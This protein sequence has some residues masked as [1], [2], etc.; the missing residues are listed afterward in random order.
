MATSRL[1]IKIVLLMPLLISCSDQTE[2]KSTDI[3]LTD[4]NAT[5]E[6]Q[7]L[8]HNLNSIRHNHILFGHQDA[9]A[10]GVTWRD[11]EGRSDVKDVAGSYPALYGWDLG[12]LELGS[13]KNLDKV[14]F[15]DIHRWIIEAFERGGVITLSW[16]LNHPVTGNRI[17]KEHNPDDWEVEG[18]A[19]D[20]TP[21][22]NDILP[23]GSHEEVFKEWLDTIA[24][25]MKSLKSSDGRSIPVIFRPYHEVTGH[26]F[27]WATEA[28]TPDEYIALWRYTVEYLRDHR[29]VNNLLYA[30]TPNSL[31]EIEW[32]EFW[33]WYPG[34]DYVDIIGFD[35]YYTLQGGYGDEDP[36][37]TFTAMLRWL[38]TEAEARNKIPVIGETGLEALYIHNWYT[39]LFLRSIKNDPIAQRIAYVLVW[40]NANKATDR[41]DHF[42]A[43]YP[44]H[45]S[46]EDFKAF[47]RDDIILLESDLPDLYR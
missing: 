46:A 38:V 47:V 39:D 33:T 28:A 10:Y 1:L 7:M 26:W 29:N 37:A 25:F 31:N 14:A 12:H 27:W 45:P 9:L 15:D 24:D 16:H 8:F 40:R 42:Y 18:S 44:D 17:Q 41:K 30:Y 23:G 20:A 36:V 35:D 3:T 13:P 34:D 5:I 32:D 22:I 43:P 4:P 2:P 21:V 6:T 19:W 11:E